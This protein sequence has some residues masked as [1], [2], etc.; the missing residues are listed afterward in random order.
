MWLGP[1]LTFMPGLRPTI[2]QIGFDSLAFPANAATGCVV[3]C[4]ISRMRWVKNQ[5]VFMLQLN[6]RWIWRVLMPFLLA[7]DQLNGLEPQAQREM[8][9][10]ED[11]ADADGERLPAGVTLAQARTASLPGEAADLLVV[12]IAAVGETGPSGHKWPRRKRKRLLRC[13]NV[14]RLKTGWAIGKFPMAS[15]LCL[16]VWGCQV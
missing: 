5:A 1:R 6:V 11:R 10:L 15:I 9:I 7:A 13:G 2:G 8:A 16:G 14:G 3:G 4:M 12:T